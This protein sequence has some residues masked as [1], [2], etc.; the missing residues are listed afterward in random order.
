MSEAIIAI[1]QRLKSFY[2]L[3]ERMGEWTGEDYK[4]MVMPLHQAVLELSRNATI[5][6]LAE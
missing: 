6:Q 3:F 1:L 4:E 2:E 5:T